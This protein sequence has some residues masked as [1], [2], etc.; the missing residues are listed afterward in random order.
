MNR[1][2]LLSM[3][4]FTA[5]VGPA[6]AKG[7]SKK[8]IA[9]S[10]GIYMNEG[11]DGYSNIVEAIFHG[12]QRGVNFDG[13]H[14]LSLR[15]KEQYQKHYTWL[16]EFILR[17]DGLPNIK[18]L[19][20]W[21]ERDVA[22][23]FYWPE[24]GEEPLNIGVDVS[25]K[26][27]ENLIKGIDENLGAINNASGLSLKLVPNKYKQ[28]EGRDFARIRILPTDYGHVFDGIADNNFS[29]LRMRH[30][31]AQLGKVQAA[32]EF[33]REGINDPHGFILTDENNEI[34]YAV[35]FVAVDMGE[36][37]TAQHI[38]KCLYRASGVINASSIPEDL[39]TQEKDKIL[40]ALYCPSVK[41]GLEE[42]AFVNTLKAECFAP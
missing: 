33:S 8:E 1:F 36:K 39:F 15:E 23:S 19:N 22:V 41:A 37:V 12:A 7:L 35:C 2:F 16:G 11:R 21:A 14:Q 5:F 38:K 18:G 42:K 30:G 28:A 27:K 3:V 17:E 10:E 29:V 25:L 20:K 34:K 24:T 26:V 32:F 9:S 40:R 13:A 31:Y 6:W 4:V